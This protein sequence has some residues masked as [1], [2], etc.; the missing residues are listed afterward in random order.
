MSPLLIGTKLIRALL[1]SAKT[2]PCSIHGPKTYP[3]L[4]KTDPCSSDRFMTG[5]L[6]IEKL[7]RALVIGSKLIRALVIGSK[8]DPCACDRFK[9]DPCSSHQSKN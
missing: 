6:V 4:Q 3:A 5:A 8:A 2:D 7:I 9:T 1:I